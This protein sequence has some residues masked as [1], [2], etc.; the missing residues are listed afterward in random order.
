MLRLVVESTHQLTLTRDRVV[1]RFRSWDKGEPEREWAGLQVLHRYAPGPAQQPLQR[2]AEDGAPV[3]VMTR[4]AGEPLGT[5]PLTREQ[6]TALSTALQVMHA[7]VPAGALTGISERRWGPAELCSTLRSWIAEPV[8]EANP[9]VS[10]SARAASSWLG[11]SEASV[12][13]GPLAERAFSRG[14]DLDNFVW[15]GAR[16]HVVDFED[17]GISDPACEVAD[18]LEHVSA[19]LPGLIK[20]D[21]L[22]EAL[23]FCAAQRARLL[24]FRRCD[25]PARRPG[26]GEPRR[27]TTAIRRRGADRR[28]ARPAARRPGQGVRA[29]VR[30]AAQTSL[31]AVEVTG[32]P[33]SLGDEADP[34]NL[35]RPKIAVPLGG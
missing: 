34:T 11:S 17:S 21:D 13:V 14:R 33:R 12:L 23:G 7:A 6:L 10:A 8:P 15:D 29:R 20:E 16:C 1:K 22:I 2:R 35:W 19:W 27:L 25:R 4:V 24:G 9:P 26:A 30:A 32:W 3:I 18:L 5:V 28:D 31:M